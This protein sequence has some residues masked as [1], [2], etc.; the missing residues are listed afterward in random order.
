MSITDPA[1]IANIWTRVRSMFVRVSDIVGAIPALA[2]LTL[3]WPSRQR[4]IASAIAL[5]ETIVR[6]LIFIEAAEMQRNQ[7][8]QASRPP[9]LEH[10]APLAAGWSA[11]LRP[12]SSANAPANAECAREGTR[13]NPSAFDP[14]QPH[15][16]RVRFKLCPPRD[17]LARSERRAPRIRALWGPSPPPPPL[18][19]P[20]A[21][22]RITPAP[23]RLAQR[24]E[25]L[26][27]AIADPLPLARKLARILP[28]LCR[29]YPQA[30]ERYATA[31]AHPHRT[32]EG[33]PRLIID[34]MVLALVAAP[35]FV[36]SS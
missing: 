14:A 9:R 30:A 16:W 36:N 22:R 32:D 11:G 12:A 21:K 35:S 31:T 28:R 7:P 17:P 2:R 24:F 18:P 27:R 33:D 15:T 20:K 29:R 6:K 23:L 5:V 19:A 26:R 10:I 25:A 1:S 8:D 3:L 34:A 13:P 4:E